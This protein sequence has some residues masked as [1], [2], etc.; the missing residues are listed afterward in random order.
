MRTT[1]D[2]PTDLHHAVTA[3][4]AHSR[5]SMSRTVAELIRRGLAQEPAASGRVSKTGL[6]IDPGTGLPL[7]R[8]PR[9]VTA[10]DVR[11][12]EDD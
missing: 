6:R 9:P 12:L 11:A 4:A 5:K 1:I 8:S 10:E 3:I 2:L 7:I